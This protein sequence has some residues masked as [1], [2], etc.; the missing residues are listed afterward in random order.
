MGWH[1]SIYFYCDVASCVCICLFGMH[2]DFHNVTLCLSKRNRSNWHVTETIINDSTQTPYMYVY[3]FI[4]FLKQVC[5]RSGWKPSYG[6]DLKVRSQCSQSHITDQQL[7]GYAYIFSWKQRTGCSWMHDSMTSWYLNPNN[8]L[9]CA[10]TQTKAA[11]FH[12]AETFWTWLAVP[13]SQQARVREFIKD[14]S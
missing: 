12:A 5:F 11:Q 1:F 2:A 3:R 4:K 9:H 13:K 14:F 7:Q 10:Y 8:F 6:L